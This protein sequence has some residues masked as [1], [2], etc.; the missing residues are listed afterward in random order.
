MSD[1]AKLV[2]YLK[3]VTT[4]L[5]ETRRRLRDAESRHREPIAIVGMACRYPGGIASPADLWAVVRDG[6]DV[7]SGF[8]QDRGWDVEAL[9]HPDPDH[10]GTSYAREGGFLYDA[11]D[12]DAAFFGISPREAQAVDPQ[13]R[14]LLELAWEVVERLGVPPEQ[15]R[16][17]LTGVFTGLMYGDY[18]ARLA[19]TPAAEWEG[20]L[21]NGSAGS[22]ASGRIAYT[23]GFEGPAVTVDTA[24]SSSLVA[25]HLACQSLRAGD[26]DL[27]LAG[28]VTVMATPGL[29]VEFSRQR[30]M[31]PDGRCK[32]FAASADGAGWAEGAGLIALE[33]LSD[34]ERN[35]HRVLAVIRGSAVNQDGASNGLTAP[36]GPAQQR[37]IRAA[38]TN[39]GL[40]PQDVDAV[41]AHGT[42]TTLGDPI[43]AQALLATY[44][45]DRDPGTPFHLGSIKSNIGHAQA[46]AGVAGIIKMVQSIAHGLLPPTL[47]VDEPTPHVDWTA[48]AVRLLEHATAWPQTDH[49]KRA[50]ISSFGISGTNAHVI[51]EQAPGD[52]PP[53]PSLDPGAIAGH[54]LPSL[55]PAA[56]EP[57]PLPFLLSAR[58]REALKA[59]AERLHAHLAAEPGL[60]GVAHALARRRTHHAHRA[61]IVAE[62]AAELTTRLR[63]LAA[64][65]PTTN[66]TTTTAA[67]GRLVFLFPGQGSQRP[68]AGRELYKTHPE[69]AAALDDVCAHLDPAVQEILLSPDDARINETFYTQTTLFA[70]QTALF[71]TL[72]HHGLKPDAL[73]GHSLGEITAAHCAG[74]L[75]LQDAARLVSTRA[76]LM[77]NLP[78]GTGAMAAIRPPAGFTNPPGTTI[79]AVNSPT[80]IV[81]AGDK[82]AVEALITDLKRAGH[83]A[84]L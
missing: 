68:G 4:E 29:F 36:N 39:A 77:Q 81:V 18:A 33:R 51:I 15:L 7:V 30:G 76:Q 24:C 31:A 21:G 13:Q 43:E 2:E 67:G 80:D 41:E 37:V 45:R 70:L 34:A 66:M 17:S 26:C 62:T 60:P 27:A 59:Q 63:D 79:A 84:K 71:R 42:G 83:K 54:P 40:R 61:V 50:A 52:P 19:G 46:A 58:S 14:L 73:T 72:I 75:T 53:S 35:G 6:R 22:V 5:H 23:F 55:D 57:R 1:E 20:L 25:T 56:A 32:S 16:G 64:G 9:Y 48:G 69:F 11:A 82:T 49:P 47:H 44:G 12:F 38:L 8:P 28:G 65:Q 74:I 78:A 10:P 3:R